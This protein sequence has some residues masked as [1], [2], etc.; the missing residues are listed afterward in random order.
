[1]NDVLGLDHGLAQLSDLAPKGYALGLHIR[2]GAAHLMIQ[3]YDPRWSETYT[4]KGY[5]LGDPMIFWG[6]GN[7]GHIRWSEITLPDPH[8]II[9]QAASFGLRYGVAI[10]MGPTN[11]RTI[12]GFARDD[13][14]FT[15]EEIA[16]IHAIVAQLHDRATP[17]DQLTSAQRMALRLVARGSRHAEA[18]ALLGISESAFK[19]RLRSARDA[20][21][22]RTTAE[23]V[24]R[25][26][27]H[28]LL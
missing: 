20:L 15:D 10:A 12:G 1:M 27:E 17:P 18:A 8:N 16:E 9:A 3:T 19:A 22:V 24:Q 28:N 25:A 14:E 6:F 23:A 4:E 11:S 13:R 21:F 2:F 5:M 26:Q 7:D